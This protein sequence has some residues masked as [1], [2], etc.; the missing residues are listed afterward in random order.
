MSDH[1]WNPKSQAGLDKANEYKIAKYPSSL[2]GPMGS[3]ERRKKTQRCMSLRR[4]YGLTYQAYINMCESQNNRCAICEQEETG[5]HKRSKN[6]EIIPLT[7]AVDHDHET[8][9]VRGLLCSKCNKALGLFGDNISML[10]KALGYLQAH[11]G[12]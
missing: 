9:A 2:Y 12:G 6:K 5:I 10:E 3:K 4:N 8:G 7:L 11:S 1:K